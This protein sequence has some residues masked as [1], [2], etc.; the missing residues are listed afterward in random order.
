MEMESLYTLVFMMSH[1]IS[2]RIFL[3]HE[4]RHKIISYTFREEKTVLQE[5]AR[6][7]VGRGLPASF[8]PSSEDSESSATSAAHVTAW[9]SW[10][11]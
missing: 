1:G 7:I 5:R 10:M 9:Q 4:Q 2:Q 3:S 11:S 6:D 8:Q